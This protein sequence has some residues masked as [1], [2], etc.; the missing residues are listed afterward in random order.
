MNIP[1]QIANIL[2]SVYGEWK[3][4]AIDGIA[5]IIGQ[6][7]EEN[8]RL[9]NIDFNART[10]ALEIAAKTASDD[11]FI[12]ENTIK[13]KRFLLNEPTLTPIHKTND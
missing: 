6:T 4:E 5:T 11:D 7:I 8:N 9:R 10:M 3:Q 13:Y 1:K 12:L 2:E